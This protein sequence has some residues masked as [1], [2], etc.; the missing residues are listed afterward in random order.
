[1]SHDDQ[2]GRDLERFRDYLTLLARLQ[3]SR[4]LRARVDVSGVVQMT[5]LEAHRA[6]DQFRGQT[7]AE[8]T[9]WLRRILANNL[10]DELRKLDAARRDVARELSLEE[11]LAES[12]SRVEAFLAARESS[13]SRQAGRA[14]ESL[15]LARALGLLP[16]KQRRAVELHHIKGWPL[17]EIA[18]ELGCTRPAVAGLLHRGLKK[19]RE[20]LGA[21]GGSES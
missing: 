20:V 19:L 5:L 1:M 14:E 21:D 9:A 16:E 13:P 18:Q 11:V 17:E 8:Q 4:K 12:S 3:V 2:P 6:R 15:R 10:A 7:E